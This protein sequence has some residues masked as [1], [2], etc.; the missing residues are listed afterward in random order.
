MQIYSCALGLLT[1]YY[2]F[3]VL[4]S[5]ARVINPSNLFEMDFLSDTSIVSTLKETRM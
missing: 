2:I 1:C 3:M 4:L 5:N